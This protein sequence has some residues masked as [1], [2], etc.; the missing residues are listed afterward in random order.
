MRHEKVPGS[1][2]IDPRVVTRDDDALGYDA[3]DDVSPLW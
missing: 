1:K 2:T 3:H